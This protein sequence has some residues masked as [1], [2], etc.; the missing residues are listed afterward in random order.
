MLVPIEEQRALQKN[1][2]WQATPFRELGKTHWTIVGYGAI[3]R[4]IAKRINPFG[5][6]ISVVRR[7]VLARDGLVDEIVALSQIDR[8]LS[9]TDVVV[10]ACALNNETRDLANERFFEAMKEGAIFINVGRGALV[11]EDALKR[12]LDRGQLGAAILDVFRTEPLPPD[13]WMWDHPD[14]RLTAHTSNRGNGMIERGDDLFLH[15]LERYIEDRP[16]LD[17]A[18]PAE[19]GLE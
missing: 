16:L 11:D 7:D 3:G 1:H 6:H 9:R 18:S 8:V 2:C 12:S 10:L 13:S 14:I 4:E 15:N 19:V 5:T 17:E